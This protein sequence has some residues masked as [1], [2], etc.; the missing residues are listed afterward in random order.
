MRRFNHAL[1]VDTGIA[2]QTTNLIAGHDTAFFD[3]RVAGRAA[4]L[5][6]RVPNCF[7]AP[8]LPKHGPLGVGAR[9]SG[10]PELERPDAHWPSDDDYSRYSCRLRCQARFSH[11]VKSSHHGPF[12]A[13]LA[14]P[15][16]G[17][18]TL[19]V[20]RASATPWKAPAMKGLS[21][22]LAK[23]TSSRPCQK[24]LWAVSLIIR[25]MQLPSC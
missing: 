4:P 10:N 11:H 6:C 14:T 12:K 24:R 3:L 7:Q 25:Y 5:S 9:P 2:E 17:P 18:P 20:H 13:R 22:A 16:P 21:S 23:T 8:F 19:M 15:G 1:I